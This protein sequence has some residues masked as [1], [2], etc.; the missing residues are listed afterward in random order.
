MPSSPRRR[1]RLS[2]RLQIE[3]RANL[4]LSA[5][6]WL[7]CGGEASK[8][9]CA[10]LGK[11]AARRALQHGRALCRQCVLESCSGNRL[12]LSQVVGV[13]LEKS[14]AAV[15]GN[16]S[17]APV[18]PTNSNAPHNMP[19]FTGQ[20]LPSSTATC[21][22]TLNT[23]PQHA[24]QTFRSGSA[25]L[26]IDGDVAKIDASSA[27]WIENDFERALAASASSC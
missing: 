16:S 12:K 20:V 11:L 13:G 5:L 2:R 17:D 9:A 24:H 4:E 14:A 15:L 18:V 27:Y 26:Q 10:G 23:L 19:A 3:Q 21:P 22:S 25:E 7:S 6:G 8:D 1:A